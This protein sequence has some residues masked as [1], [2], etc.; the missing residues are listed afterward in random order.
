MWLTKTISSWE[1]KDLVEQKYFL[2]VIF[3]FDEQ[4]FWLYWF[5]SWAPCYYL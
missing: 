5:M 4:L 1:T 2:N 3:H